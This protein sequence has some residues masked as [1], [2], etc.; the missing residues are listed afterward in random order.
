MTEGKPVYLLDCDT[1]IDD[2]VALLYLLGDRSID[3]AAVTITFGNVTAAQA[4]DNTLRLLHRVGRDDIPVAVGSELSVAGG[5]LVDRGQNRIHGRNGI[6]DVTLPPS[7]NAPVDETAPEL[8]VR[9]A[10]EHAGRLHLIVTGVCTNLAH[11]LE[12]DP[13]LPELVA[14]V[15]IMGGAA[16]VP[17]NATAAAEA[18]I[19]HDPVAAARVLRAP[20]PVT[21]VPLDVTMLD[22][23]EQP[24]WQ[25]LLAATGTVGELAAQMMDVYMDFYADRYG[26]RVAACHD[27]LAAAIAVGDIRPTLA[28]VIDVLVDT[29]DGPG[30]GQTICDLRDRFRGYDRDVDGGSRVVLE[31]GERFVPRLLDRLTSY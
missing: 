26:R 7:P 5:E 29:T 20:W 16:M 8:I 12:L 9:L 31:L 21:L 19:I 23:I 24:E 25:Q 6:G 28:P 3:L 27:V 4:A 13:E 22:V 30:R 15:T 11:A 18:N 14:S 2:A 1:G 10:H 17:G